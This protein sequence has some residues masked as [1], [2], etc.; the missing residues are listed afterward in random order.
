MCHKCVSR[1]TAEK[2]EL[3]FSVAEDFGDGAFWAFATEQGVDVDDLERYGR[4][5]EEEAAQ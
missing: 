1:K 4:T 5:H 3:L 2:I